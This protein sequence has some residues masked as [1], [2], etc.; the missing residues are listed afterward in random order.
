VGLA[1]AVGIAT[2]DV[3]A[4]ASRLRAL[5]RRL[6][7]GIRDAVADVTV[8]GHPENR[9]PGLLNISCSFVEGES[10]VLGLDMDGFAVST[11]SACTTGEPEPSHVITALGV[12]PSLAQGSLRFS[13]GRD[14]TAEEVDRLIEVF[15]AIVERLRA[16]SPLGGK[17]AS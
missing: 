12:T 9:L 15:P 7:R 4:T 10:L 16:I 8:N 17:T 14:N 11:G 13:L 6:D 1:E 2:E 3:E 5:E